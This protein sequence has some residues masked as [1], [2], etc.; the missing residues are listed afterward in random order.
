MRWSKYEG[1]N[2]LRQ[3]RERHRL[4][5]F[6]LLKISKCLGHLAVPTHHESSNVCHAKLH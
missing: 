2:P 6:F 5:S 4:I 3:W 1:G